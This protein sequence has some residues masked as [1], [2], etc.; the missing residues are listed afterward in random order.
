MKKS[1]KKLISWIAIPLAI[2]VVLIAVCL[3]YL[4]TYYKAVD[5]ELYMTSSSNCAVTKTKYGYYFDGEGEQDALIFYPG[6]K[7]EETAYS[8][9]LYQLAQNGIDCYLVKMPFHMAIFGVNKAEK[10]IDDTHDNWYVGGHSMGG[11]MAAS[12]ASKTQK[13]LAGVILFSAYSANDCT[14][15]NIRCLSIYGSCDGVLGLSKVEK[16]R[17]YFDSYV[18]YVI[19]GG[20][21]AQMGSYGFQKGDRVATITPVQQ[22]TETVDQ[23][24]SFVKN[25]SQ[26]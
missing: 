24:V 26:N 8:P 12:F 11:A 3:G 15:K 10:M 5:V 14:G 7:V 21:H 25:K 19:Q 1:K 2:V 18:E 13:K 20:N 17:S 9:I 16:G 4:C 23:I 6:A 22:W